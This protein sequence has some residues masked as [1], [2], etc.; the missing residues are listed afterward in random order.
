MENTYNL[1][2]MF[3]PNINSLLASN[4]KKEEMSGEFANYDKLQL[5]P[6]MYLVVVL[7]LKFYVFD[8]QKLANWLMCYNI[9]WENVVDT[10][11]LDNM[12]KLRAVG[13]DTIN[14]DVMIYPEQTESWPQEDINELLN[15]P[16]F[17]IICGVIQIT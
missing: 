16:N 9:S 2:S 15:Q 11:G 4:F 3:W 8:E 10:F 17:K 12:R 5:Y 6:L 1:V 7:T 14:K 13:G